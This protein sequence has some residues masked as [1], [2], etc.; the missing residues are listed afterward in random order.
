MRQI[1]NRQDALTYIHRALRYSGIEDNQTFDAKQL[2]QILEKY[3]EDCDPLDQ[4]D[5]DYIMELLI[6]AL[7]YRHGVQKLLAEAE[8]IVRNN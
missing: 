5:V 1:E 8:E 6:S 3:D 4:E 2:P 7:M